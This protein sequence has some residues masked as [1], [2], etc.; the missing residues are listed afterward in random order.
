MLVSDIISR[1][2]AVLNDDNV[3]W[4]EA[5]DLLGWANEAI[6]E[7]IKVKPDVYTTEASLSLSA[8]VRQSLTSGHFRIL[9][10]LG[11]NTASHKDVPVLTARETMD[12]YKPDW[13]SA[14][15]QEEVEVVVYDEN[16]PGSFDVYPPNDGNGALMLVTSAPPTKLT[17]VGD[18][19]P[20]SD[21]YAGTTVN[22][23]LYR[24]FAK[25]SDA[26]KY[27]ERSQQAYKAF[28]SDLGRT[29]LV[30]E[31]TTPKE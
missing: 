9:E 18:T 8:G 3:H 28:L 22:Y 17:D 15:Q 4:P 21:F 31:K 5:T 12:V 27:F 23:L 7:I 11:N 14:T 25:D 10:V 6:E 19:F 16:V 1:A 13:R 29:E 20:L 24:A 30:E 2:Q 26:V